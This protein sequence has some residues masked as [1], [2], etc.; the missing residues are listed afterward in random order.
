MVLF[1]FSTVPVKVNKQNMLQEVS[2]TLVI[3][4]SSN[5]KA[6]IGTGSNK[7]DEIKALKFLLTVAAEGR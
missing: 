5:F 6:F 1:Q 7:C 4:I 3:L 2:Y